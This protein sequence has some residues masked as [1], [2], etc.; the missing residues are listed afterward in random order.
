MDIFTV[1]FYQPIYNAIVI[2]YRF[3][4]NELGL[5][6]IAIALIARLLLSPFTIRQVKMAEMSREF[7]EKSKDI[8]KKYK[9]DKEKQQEE[10]VKLQ[11]EYLPAQVSGCLPLIFQLIFFINLYRV[12]SNIV[13]EGG[14]GFN[15]IAYSFVP[16]FPEG[17][18][19]NTDFLGIDLSISANELSFSNTEILPYI[20]LVVLVGL[21]QFISMRVLMG[22]R[23]NREV[24]NGK[25]NKKK[26]KPKKD[27][28]APE[29]FSEIV[30]KSTKQTMFLLPIIF[31]F[32][33]Y[34]L[35]S[36]LSL[37]WT[38]QSSFV[39]IQQLFLHYFVF[40]P[41]LEVKEK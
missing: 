3:F 21:M 24:Q 41:K 1:L 35:P 4:G 27:P 18:V 13:K 23:K 26:K 36:G 16:Q 10:L 25:N 38:V 5:A 37:Y 14:A 2:L 20:I 28:N 40:K 11:A 8:R 7:S 30:E 31:V 12:I 9:K 6:I 17:K 22:L 39:I 15:D 32:I 34:S 29:D 19:F 33:S